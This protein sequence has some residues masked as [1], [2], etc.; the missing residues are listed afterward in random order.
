VRLPRVERS[1]LPA[2]ADEL[3]VVLTLDA[4]G[5][6]FLDKV[7]ATPG[8]GGPLTLHGLAAS[9]HPVLEAGPTMRSPMGATISSANVLLRAD[10]DAPWLHVAWVMTIL[11]EQKLYRLS[12]AAATGDGAESAAGHPLR[13]WLPLAAPPSP[14]PEETF[15]IDVA[16]RAL[17][18]EEVRR[19]EATAR[20]PA[21][22]EYVFGEHQTRDRSEIARWILEE[23]EAARADGIAL[24]D[25]RGEVKAAETMPAGRVAEALAMFLAAGLVEIHFEGVTFPDEKTRAGAP[26]PFPR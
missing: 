1:G 11:A 14:R 4:R 18:H 16:L 15:T 5:G 26:L 24:E 23:V 10:R 25:L 3:D 21:T 6:I 9:L 19:G 13:S 17:G 20:V 2:P 12:M 7:F 22:V 8:P